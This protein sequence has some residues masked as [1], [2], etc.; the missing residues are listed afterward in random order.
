MMTMPS[1]PA[2]ATSNQTAAMI[3]GPKPLLRPM[4][5]PGPMPALKRLGTQPW[6]RPQ[7]R[8]HAWTP[9]LISLRSLIR[10]RRIRR[11]LRSAS[12]PGRWRQPS[13]P[14]AASRFRSASWSLMAAR[15]APTS[16]GTARTPCRARIA[17]QQP[18][19]RDAYTCR[20]LPTI[21]S[22]STVAV[23]LA[24]SCY[25]RPLST[26][27]LRAAVLPPACPSPRRWSRGSSRDH[28]RPPPPGDAAAAGASPIRGGD[29]GGRADLGFQRADGG[30]RNRRQP[31]KAA[32]DQL[33]QVPGPEDSTRPAPSG[34]AMPG[35]RFVACRSRNPTEKDG[36]DG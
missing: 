34:D 20:R 3:P 12:G 22:G 18:I 21:P 27:P 14:C 8:R 32:S 11:R 35:C 2:M 13:A 29:R 1:H 5:A 24:C 19:R 15:R 9:Y 36:T 10:R 33:H 31:A 25:R 23:V 16:G 26:R 17:G 30:A 6:R 4:P 28:R 7:L